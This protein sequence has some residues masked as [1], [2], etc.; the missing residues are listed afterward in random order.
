[1]L[2]ISSSSM[3]W[4]WIIKNIFALDQFNPQLTFI[5]LLD[6]CSL[7]IDPDKR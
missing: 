1:M 2:G 4:F 6:F 3:P 5:E 7:G